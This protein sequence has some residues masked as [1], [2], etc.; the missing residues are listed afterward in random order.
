MD[1]RSRSIKVIPACAAA[2]A[3]F[4]PALAAPAH[5]DE[6]GALLGEVNAARAANGCGPV[7]A[8]PQLTAAAARQANDMLANN[9]RSHTGSDG[10]SVGQRITAA[11][12]TQYANVGEI[13]FWSTGVNGVPAAAVNWWMNSPGH[14]AIITD[15]GM[16]EAGFS[17]ARAGNRATAVGEFGTK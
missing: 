1:S 2:L 4:S 8:N 15:C 11:G 9:V 17:V 10:S 7:A 12:Y 3:L 13:I 16:T 6:G 5:A 14:R